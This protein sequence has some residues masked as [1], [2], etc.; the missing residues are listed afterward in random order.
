[1]NTRLKHIE[2]YFYDEV[3]PLHVDIVNL[4]VDPKDIKKILEDLYGNN[5]RYVAYYYDLVKE[6]TLH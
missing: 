6:Y 2:V 4:Q 5:I 1:M 3:E